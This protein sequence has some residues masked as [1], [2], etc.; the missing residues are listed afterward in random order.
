MNEYNGNTHSQNNEMFM[1]KFSGQK[2]PMTAPVVTQY[3]PTSG[4]YGN[5][6]MFF[7]IPFNLQANPPAPTDADVFIERAPEM[8]FYVK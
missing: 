2:I 6:S 5:V 7:M 8:W 4:S 1:V 3:T